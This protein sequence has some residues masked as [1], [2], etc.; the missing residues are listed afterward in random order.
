MAKSEFNRESI[1]EEATSNQLTMVWTLVADA[2]L[3][4]ELIAPGEIADLADKVDNYITEHPMHGSN[5]RAALLQADQ[6]M[7]KQYSQPRMDPKAV[8]SAVE[9]EAFKRKARSVALHAA[10]CSICLGL[11]AT[12]QL[13][14]NQLQRIFLLADISEGEIEAGHYQL[15]DVAQKIENA[16]ALTQV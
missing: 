16:V 13:S 11:N 5:L 4:L 1:V 9:L 2:I 3:E 10:K 6:I 15:K 14:R 12:G 8:R 7:G